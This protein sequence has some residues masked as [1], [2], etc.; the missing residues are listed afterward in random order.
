VKVNVIEPLGNDMDVYASTSLHDHVVAR[1]EAHA[2]LQIDA[3]AALY[4]DARKIHFF[5]P[6]VT[7]MNLCQASEL[8]HAPI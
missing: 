3:R 5:A 4:A 6:G 2:G 8:S 7:G 1:V